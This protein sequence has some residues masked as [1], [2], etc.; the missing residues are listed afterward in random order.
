MRI[1]HIINTN[2]LI[3]YKPSPESLELIGEEARKFISE[4]F[5]WNKDHCPTLIDFCVKAISM[6]FERNPL[7]HELTCMDRDHLLEMLSSDLSLKIAVTCIYVCKTVF[8]SYHKY[9]LHL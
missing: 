3:E 5:D 4:N 1:P 6:Y 2:T 7:F 9:F 8:D